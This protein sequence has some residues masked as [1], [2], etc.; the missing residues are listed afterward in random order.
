MS[1]ND[2]NNTPMLPF[3]I[4]TVNNAQGGTMIGDYAMGLDWNLEGNNFKITLTDINARGVLKNVQ[5]F[6]INKLFGIG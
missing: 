3:D 5:Y 1:L 6:E 4:I 2:T